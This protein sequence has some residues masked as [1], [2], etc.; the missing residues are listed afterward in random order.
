MLRQATYTTLRLGLYDIGR[1][2]AIDTAERRGLSG[3]VKFAIRQIVGAVS[4]AIAS[5]IS[6]PVEV[7]L[8]RMQA[9]GKQ[10]PNKRRNY[11]N[12][13]DAL[14]RIGREEGVKAYWTGASTTVIRFVRHLQP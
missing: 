4:G 6:C 11:K 1:K 10:P 5:F 2:L 14:V 3:L 13:I 12:I 8:V 9:D 7:C